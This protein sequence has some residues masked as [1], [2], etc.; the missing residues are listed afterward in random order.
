MFT[1][2]LVPYGAGVAPSWDKGGKERRQQRE[3]EEDCM[4]GESEGEEKE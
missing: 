4:R 2:L 1:C 3:A